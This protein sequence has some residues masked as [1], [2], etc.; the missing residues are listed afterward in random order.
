MGSEVEKRRNR[1]NPESDANGCKIARE[2][3][4]AVAKKRKEI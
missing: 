2:I 1:W 3:K 4:V